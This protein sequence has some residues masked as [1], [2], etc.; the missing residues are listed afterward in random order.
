MYA[1]TLVSIPSED[2]ESGVKMVIRRTPKLDDI[3]TLI[4]D[5]DDSDYESTKKEKTTNKPSSNQVTTTRDKNQSPAETVVNAALKKLGIEEKKSNQQKNWAR[6]NR[7]QRDS[8]RSY[9]YAKRRAEIQSPS[10]Y[11]YIR[12]L[13]NGSKRITI[14]VEGNI[15][16]GKTTLINK[17]QTLGPACITTIREPLNQWTKNS[18]INLLEKMY[19]DPKKWSFIFQSLAMTNMLQNH[20]APGKTKIMERSLGAAFH[21]FLHLHHLNETMDHGATMALQ[22]WYHTADDLYVIKPDLII[23]LRASPETAMRRLKIRDRNEEKNISYK[24]L[25]QVHKF[26]DQWLLNETTDVKVIPIN[27][28]QSTDEMLR[29]LNIQVA[30]FNLKSKF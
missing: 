28:D 9:P 4:L 23:Y 17:L 21:V 16:I 5:S 18:N 8:I 19:R 29:D 24:Y 7:N 12:D 30:H 1:N 2:D 11:G 6:E 25:T 13:L 20:L 14:A 3:P 27:A 10:T 15:D 22:E 26:Y